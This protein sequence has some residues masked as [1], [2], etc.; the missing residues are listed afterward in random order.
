MAFHLKSN[1]KKIY[2]QITPT[3]IYGVFFFNKANEEI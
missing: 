1:T 3:T 2:M